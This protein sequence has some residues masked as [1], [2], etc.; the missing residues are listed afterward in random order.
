MT[1]SRRVAFV[2]SN[3][4]TSSVTGRPIQPFWIEAEAAKLPNTTFV[5]GPPMES[6]AIVDGNL[7][8]GQQQHSGAEAAL[9]AT[10]LLS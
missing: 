4:A 9:L 2:I 5:A 1:T 7:V 3:K 8:A 10:G 6:H